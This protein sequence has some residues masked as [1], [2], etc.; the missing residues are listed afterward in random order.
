M[1]LSNLNTSAISKF[2]AT[3]GAFI[4][5]FATD[6]TEPTRMEIGADGLLYALQWSGSGKVRRYNLDGTS[7]G[8]FTNVGVSNSIGMTWTRPATYTFLLMM[9]NL[10]ENLAQRQRSR[11]ICLHEPRWADQYL[12]RCGRQPRGRRL[13]GR[14]CETV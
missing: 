3:T 12:V 1:L 13:F 7:L 4:D 9:E 10:S 5:E 2:D 14:G 6:I 8:D 11:Q